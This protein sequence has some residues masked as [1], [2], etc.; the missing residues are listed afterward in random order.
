MTISAK[1][2]PIEYIGDG[3]TRNFVPPFRFFDREIEVTINGK[4]TDK[5]DALN[6]TVVFH[7]APAK[8]SVVVFKRKVPLEQQIKFI[9]GENFPASDFEHSLD[10]LYMALQ[11]LKYNVEN[12]KVPE[13]PEGDDD[14][15]SGDIDNRI[16]ALVNSINAIFTRLS[17]TEG[18][19][20]TI[21]ADVEELQRVVA[22]HSKKILRKVVHAEA[23]VS[24]WKTDWM[25]ESYPYCIDINCADT[26]TM[27]IDNPLWTLVPTVI[28]DPE[29][30][31]SGNFSSY[32]ETGI[33]PIHDT[34]SPYY[35]Y[36]FYVRI[37]AK[38]IPT[39]DFSVSIKLD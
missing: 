16:Q 7:T 34:S 33:K 19:I 24:E 8:D 37:Y 39:E 12:I 21:Q 2:E 22:D 23:L 15:P 13:I 14:D 18:D 17:K 31:D 32:S 28:F 38:E 35:P 30:A 36:A 5:F 1:Y 25:F 26:D 4:P 10:R 29:Q 11:E 3:S 6:G 20:K 9:E 27:E